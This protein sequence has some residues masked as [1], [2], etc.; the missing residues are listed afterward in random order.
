[1]RSVLSVLSVLGLLVRYMALLIM[2]L[3]VPLLISI[4][5]PGLSRRPRLSLDLAPAHRTRD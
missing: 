5:G 2:R 1:M 3:L 4:R